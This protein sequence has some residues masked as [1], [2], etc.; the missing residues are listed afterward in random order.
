MTQLR[1][2]RQKLQ[3]LNTELFK[4]LA[5]RKATARSIQDQKKIDNY[6]TYDA[7]RELELFLSLEKELRSLC[8]KELLAFSLL[9]ESHAGQGYPQW[10]STV[11]LAES[12]GNLS[13]QINPLLLLLFY[14]HEIKVKALKSE[15]KFL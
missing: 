5:E 8:I 1:E 10:S 4:V 9:M 6:P 15:F 12:T 7:K 11:H 13:S 2:L 3:T 14:P